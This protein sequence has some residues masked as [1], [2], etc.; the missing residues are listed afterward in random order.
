MAAPEDE[1]LG[2]TPKAS[3]RGEPKGAM[4]R[5]DPGSQV[6]H[7]RKIEGAGET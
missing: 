2:A 5:G 6:R 3:R 4:I 7:Y 1:R